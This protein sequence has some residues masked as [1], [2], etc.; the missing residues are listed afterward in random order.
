MATDLGGLGRR[1]D[2]VADRLERGVDVKVKRTALAIDQV[3]VLATPVDQGRARSNWRVSVSSPLEGVIDP[4]APGDGLGV[5][6]TENAREALAQGREAIGARRPGESIF[7]TN[8]LDYIVFLND[9]SSA[10][11]PAGFVEA[12]IEAGRR[13]AREGGVIGRGS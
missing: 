2:L 11:A 4:Y 13:V 6:E 12:A 9:G 7:I 1:L 10:Q 3:L 5:G 8:N